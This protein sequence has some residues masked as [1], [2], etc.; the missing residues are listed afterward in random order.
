MIDEKM[1]DKELLTLTL[2]THCCSLLE[3]D[4]ECPVGVLGVRGLM[5]MELMMRN[6][7][8]PQNLAASRK[9]FRMSCDLLRDKQESLSPLLEKY[10]RNV[11]EEMDG[12]NEP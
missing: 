12:R 8:D 6:Q 1:N 5:M 9:F 4:D 11:M 3:Q 7:S 2:F 10:W